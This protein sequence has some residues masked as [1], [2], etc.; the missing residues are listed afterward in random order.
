M[1]WLLQPAGGPQEAARVP[2]PGLQ[3]GV[4]EDVAPARA[5]AVALGG[6]ALPVQLAVLRQEV[7]YTAFD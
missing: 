6:A 7:S 5:P 1:T 3:Q 4:R 2:H